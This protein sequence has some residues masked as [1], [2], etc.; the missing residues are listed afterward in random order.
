[1][2][3]VPLGA[4][5]R[6]WL[7]VVCGA[8]LLVGVIRW[9]LGHETE[10]GGTAP[11][12]V[13]RAVTVR[14]DAIALTFPVPRGTHGVTATLAALAKAPATFFV[15]SHY[16]HRHPG[17]LR[18]LLRAGQEVEVLA[19]TAHTPVCTAVRPLE[20]VGAQPTFLQLRGSLLPPPGLR[21]AAQRCG[22]RPVAWSSTVTVATAI[23]AT[24][25][26]ARPGDILR[27]PVDAAVADS[28][29][30]LLRTLRTRG[31]TPLTLEA[32]VALAQGGATIGSHGLA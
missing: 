10:P 25:M 16:A 6:R 28:L 29:P 9:G 23:G 31:Y 21:R 32:L 1:M 11:V 15:G 7:A 30:S 2:I 22:L 12:G 27:L 20:A 13:L 18:Q 26:T 4:A 14:S 17:H 19:P 24:P 3:V 8:A 5:I